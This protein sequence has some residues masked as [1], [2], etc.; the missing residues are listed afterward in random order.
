M[1][2]AEFIIYYATIALAVSLVVILVRFKQLKPLFSA[3]KVNAL[4]EHNHHSARQLTQLGIRIDG[5]GALYWIAPP[6]YTPDEQLKVGAD[7]EVWVSD[8]LQG[9]ILTQEP[10]TSVLLA[11]SFK[12]GLIVGFGLLIPVIFILRGQ[13]GAV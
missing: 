13:I 4:I 6:P 1:T 3:K 11:K 10:K 12:P 9:E 7:I 8:H 2:K 5:K